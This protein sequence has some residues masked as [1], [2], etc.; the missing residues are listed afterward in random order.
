M[1]NVY[2]LHFFQIDNYTVA[3]CALIVPDQKTYSEA[4]KF[5]SAQNVT[6]FGLQM[7]A[8]LMDLS[9]PSYANNLKGRCMLTAQDSTVHKKLK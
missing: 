8:Q 9:G 7:S 6:Y 4:K 5:C 1:K 2:Y 3:K